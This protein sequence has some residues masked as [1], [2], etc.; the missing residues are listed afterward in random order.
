MSVVVRGVRAVGA[1]LKLGDVDLAVL[2]A[3]AILVL[4]GH[5]HGHRL[6]AVECLLRLL[7][8]RLIVEVFLALLQGPLEL[9]GEERGVVVALQAIA[10]RE[11][12]V[13]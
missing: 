8:Q 1:G 13:G 11:N 2:R 4:V 3:V 5:V 6:H 10:V 9:P 7:I 12:V